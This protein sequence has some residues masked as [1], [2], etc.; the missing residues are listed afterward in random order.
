MRLREPRAPSVLD[1]KPVNII[2]SYIKN[3]RAIRLGTSFDF[4]GTGFV[5][6]SPSIKPTIKK[7]S[8]LIKTD[9]TRL[10]EQL[11]R[12]LSIGHHSVLRFFVH[13]RRAIVELKVKATVA[14]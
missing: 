2:E 10:K 13:V 3:S 1:S 5:G 8:C 9:G 6:N 4:D 11:A 12:G 7:V 14:I